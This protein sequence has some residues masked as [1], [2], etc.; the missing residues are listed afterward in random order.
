MTAAEIDEHITRIY[1]IKRRIGE[2]VSF[3]TISIMCAKR[4]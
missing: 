2:G 1:D 4:T 3:T